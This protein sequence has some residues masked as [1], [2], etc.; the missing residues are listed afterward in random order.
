MNAAGPVPYVIV[1]KG[2]GAEAVLSSYEFLNKGPEYKLFQSWLGE[3]LLTSGDQKWRERR[4]F[5]TPAFHFQTLQGF[6]PIFNK[7]ADVFVDRLKKR[8]QSNGVFDIYPFVTLCTL[9]IIC[10]M[11]CGIGQDDTGSH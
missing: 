11:R 4:K 10:G 1:T 2:L 7:Q 3:G 6:L 5:L 9:D 8:T